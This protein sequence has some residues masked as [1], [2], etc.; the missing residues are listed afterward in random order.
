MYLWQRLSSGSV[1]NGL[2]AWSEFQPQTPFT[3]AQYLCI[4]CMNILLYNLCSQFKNT[5]KPLDE[6][7][8]LVYSELH[9]GT[10]SSS[11][12]QIIRVAMET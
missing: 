8:H 9:Y 2:S 3:A 6:A 12:S 11:R 5:R 4:L 1:L 7:E 10:M